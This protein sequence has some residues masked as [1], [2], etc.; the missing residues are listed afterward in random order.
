MNPHKTLSVLS[1]TLL[2]TILMIS[3]C[4]TA[5]PEIVTMVVEGADEEQVV[6]TQAVSVESNSDD[7][8]SSSNADNNQRLIIKN[9]NIVIRI[10][11][12]HDYVDQLTGIAEQY[13]G[14]VLTSDL[15][16]DPAGNETLHM[17]IAVEVDHFESA[18]MGVRTIGGEVLEETSSGED[19][20]DEFVDL[21]SRLGSLRATRDRLTSFLEQADTV[22]EAL[23]VN[24]ALSEIE[25]EIDQILGRME[26]LSGR[27]AFSTIDIRLVPVFLP[28]TPTPAP[29]WEPGKIVGQAAEA[30]IELVK[31]LFGALV[32][33]VVFLGPYLVI[34]A[35]G[36][37]LIRRWRQR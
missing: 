1:L 6:T 27:A 14:Y 4:S 28:P 9:G 17:T 35:F 2:T 24:E 25:G 31:I 10:A 3:G 20:T 23:E 15:R 26:Y 18:M 12:A 13:G 8:I 30:Q 16:A 21:E 11:N 19:V 22:E 37:W 5:E 33:I 7:A 29:I 32:W 34:G 36:F